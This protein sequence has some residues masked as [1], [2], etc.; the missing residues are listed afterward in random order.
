MKQFF[1]IPKNL[2]LEQM[3]IEQVLCVKH[4]PGPSY[5]HE[6]WIYDVNLIETRF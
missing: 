3:F 5:L 2:V 4:C 6:N 1:S